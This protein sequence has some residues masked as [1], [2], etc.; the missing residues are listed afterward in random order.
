[1]RSLIDLHDAPIYIHIIQTDLSYVARKP[2]GYCS[3]IINFN[4]G[5]T[6]MS[7]YK[8]LASR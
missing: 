7:V 3:E 6:D 4:T 1:M 5:L 2:S 8:I